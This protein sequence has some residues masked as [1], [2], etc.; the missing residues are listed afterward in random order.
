LEGAF[1]T[2]DIV[3]AIA[4]QKTGVRKS[5]VNQDNSQDNPQGNPQG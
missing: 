4:G 3:T 2:G 5:A 1:N